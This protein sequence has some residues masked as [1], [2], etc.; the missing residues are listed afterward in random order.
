MNQ[1]Q[2]STVFFP[3]EI[4]YLRK[5]YDDSQLKKALIYFDHV[6]TVVPETTFSGD[7]WVHG[8]QGYGARSVRIEN[9]LKETFPL[10]E[11][12]I[13]TCVN[14][15]ENVYSRDSKTHFYS[16]GEALVNLQQ[17][18]DIEK[19]TAELM[20]TSIV[21]DISNDGFRSLVNKLGMEPIPVFTGQLE[22]NWFLMLARAG[23]HR[24]MWDH[25]NPDHSHGGFSA[26]V[27]P[28]LG[29]AVLLNHALMTSI[30]YGAFPTANNVVFDQLLKYKLKHVLDVPA[31]AE[32]LQNTRKGFSWDRELLASDVLE[33][34][35]PKLELETFE[36]VLIFREKMNDELQAFKSHLNQA[37]FQLQTLPVS[38]VP[39]A[40]NQ[41]VEN[42]IL[43]A[44]NDLKKSLKT[45]NDKFILRVV[46]G[47]RSAEATIPLIGSIFVGLP[48]WLGIAL[49]AGAAVSEAA[50][51][52]YFERRELRENNGLSFL[53]R[54]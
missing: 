23:H 54:F 9:F 17:I 42:N 7:N 52:T 38:E 6:F 49:S 31:L 5:D 37:A 16:L 2:L 21:A 29:A 48:L 18:E 43:P 24:D 53:L 41:I 8:F 25:P 28:E 50:V 46:K 3:G 10:R 22:I 36:D 15:T 34:A 4:D 26:M 1:E 13:L 44:L 30:R 45:S 39:T 35:L 47:L 51:E 33:I 14:P 19:C 20:F 12:G 27:S 40:V 32:L 11:A